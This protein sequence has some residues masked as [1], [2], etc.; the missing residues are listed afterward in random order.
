MTQ[1]Q[2]NYSTLIGK[3]KEEIIDILLS[4]VETKG[5]EE[6]AEYNQNVHLKIL[7]LKSYNNFSPDLINQT[8]SKEYFDKDKTSKKLREFF[9]NTIISVIELNDGIFHLEIQSKR[10]KKH[11]HFI[12]FLESL[13]W[14]IYTLVRKNELDKSI[15]RLKNYLPDLEYTEIPPRFLENLGRNQNF[16]ESIRGFIAKYDPRYAERRRSITVNVF[17]GDLGDLDMLR[18]KFFVEPTTLSFRKENSPRVEGKMFTN[19]LVSIMQYD[20]TAL[21]MAKQTINDVIQYYIDK[22][23][24]VY[25]QVETYENVP[26]LGKQNTSLILNSMYCL[27]MKINEKRFNKDRKDSITI[28]DLNMS[29]ITYFEN[30]KSR[31]F[32]YSE[33]EFSHFIFDR[34][35]K[36]KVQI[37]I[38]PD[39][40]SI[41]IYPFKN[42]KD[43]TIRDI[44]SGFSNSVEASFEYIDP[45]TINY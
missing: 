23:K 29:I 12:I 39:P 11:F 2:I 18:E 5:E 38:E 7:I 17:G 34:E 14:L 43:R 30:R 24:Q 42:C 41:I 15:K 1:P 6:E 19:G 40:H 16:K 32:F 28:Q 33:T 9:D 36:N 25:E 22:D 27:V 21:E 31:Y 10:S 26:K 3:S 4:Q 35:T 20:Q 45:F 8:L 37:T 13:Y 44:V